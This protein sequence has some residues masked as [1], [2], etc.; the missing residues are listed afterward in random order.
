MTGGHRGVDAG[1]ARGH[2][3]VLGH[4]EGRHDDCLGAVVPWLVLLVG[5]RREGKQDKLFIKIP[6]M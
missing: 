6:D 5:K 2:Y 1:R 4:L 3:R